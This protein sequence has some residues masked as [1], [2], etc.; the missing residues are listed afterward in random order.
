[1]RE[2][3]YTDFHG[4]AI[5]KEALRHNFIKRYDEEFITELLPYDGDPLYWLRY[6]QESIGFNLR[7]I[8]HIL[9]M[10]FLPDQWK[11]SLI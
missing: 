9:L 2:Q 3:G 11:V 8:H 7:P 6:L 5:N 1:M 4:T 10:F